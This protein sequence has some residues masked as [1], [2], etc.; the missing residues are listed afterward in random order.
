MPS[1]R[2]TSTFKK[3]MTEKKGFDAWDMNHVHRKETEQ[4]RQ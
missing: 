3:M 1:D 2:R 4:S